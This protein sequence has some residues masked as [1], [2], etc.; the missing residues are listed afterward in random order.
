MKVFT[1]R[2]AAGSIL[3]AMLLPVGSAN[4][5]LGDILKHGE[6]S[7]ASAGLGNLGSVGSTG[8]VAGVL[9]FCL[10]NNFLGGQEASSVKDKLT[11]KLPGGAASSDEGYK[12]G[13]QGLLKSGEGKQLDLSGGGMKADVTKQV[14]NQVLSQGKSLL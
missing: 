8:N 9:E 1:C 3:L 6:N 14:C 5:Q 13:A 10:K 2:N 7:G 11:G 4:A 12:N